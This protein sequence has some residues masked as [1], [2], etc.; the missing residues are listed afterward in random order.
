MTTLVSLYIVKIICG[1]RDILQT[2]AYIRA[3]DNNTCLGAIPSQ[4]PAVW[5]VID[6]EV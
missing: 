2:T 6:G 3:A 4:R 1:W 5:I